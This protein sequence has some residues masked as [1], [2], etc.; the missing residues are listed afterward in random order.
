MKS[1]S[2]VVCLFGLGETEEGGRDWMIRTGL[3]EN[4]VKCIACRSFAK[5]IYAKYRDLAQKWR[6]ITEPFDAVYVVFIGYY[7]MPL[8]WYLARRRKVPVILDAFIS[9]YDTEVMDRKRV[10]AISLRAWFL[11]LVDWFACFL[12]DAIVV[13][14]RGHKNYFAK[15][16]F[17][18]P[19]K[20]IVVPIGSRSDVFVPVMH[21]ATTGHA[22][23]I[24]FHG[25]FIPLQG[26]EHILGAAKSI[27]DRGEQVQ[28]EIIGDGQT[29]PAMRALAMERKLTN[30]TF[31]GP[32]THAEVVDAIHR[33]DICL[34]IFGTTD[35]ALRVIPNKVYECLACGKP[36]ITERSPAALEYLRDGEEVRMVNPGDSADLA[37]KIIELKNNEELRLRLGTAARAISMEAFSTRMIVKDLVAWLTTLI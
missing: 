2:P 19:K 31:T 21:S 12:A 7:F 33:A 25:R 11:W 13:D 1:R 28:F 6:A 5:G 17:V 3:E 15:H 9:Q 36:V 18:N 34:G 35:K 10:A 27:A 22:F 30:V 29:Y 26:I 37:E 8:A 14:T 16:L 32:K 4:G 20:I 24:E 23:T